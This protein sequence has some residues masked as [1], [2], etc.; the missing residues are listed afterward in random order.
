[1]GRGTIHHVGTCGVHASQG[2]VFVT[3]LRLPVT[4]EFLRSVHG[5]AAIHQRRYGGNARSLTVLEP[6]A[7]TTNTSAEIRRETEL[8]SSQYRSAATAIAVEGEGFAAAAVRTLI[9]GIHLVRRG[10]GQFKITGTAR[11]AVRW[12]LS[13]PAPQGTE[14]SDEKTLLEFVERVRRADAKDV[15]R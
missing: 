9:A 14:T 1:M 5:P 8:V 15:T 4:L 11:D 10:H 12:L 3:L 2:D 6:G 7:I 13:Q